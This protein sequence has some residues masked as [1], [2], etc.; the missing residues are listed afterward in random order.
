MDSRRFGTKVFYCIA[1]I[2]ALLAAA[3]LFYSKHVEYAVEGWI[4]FYGA[5]GFVSC[6]LLVLAAVQLRRIVKRGE[7]YYD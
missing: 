3:D 4:G 6:V 1:A 5:Y 2:C 7:D